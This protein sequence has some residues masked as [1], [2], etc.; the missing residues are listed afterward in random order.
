[1]TTFQLQQGV[2]NFE[3]PLVIPNFLNEIQT[4]NQNII[5][6]A[7]SSQFVYV[8]P[9]VGYLPNQQ[10]PDEA[11]NLM[12]HFMKRGFVLQYDGVA[13]TLTIQWDHPEMSD[14]LMS[15]ISY[16]SPSVLPTLGGW[17]EAGVVYLCETSG[18]DL[19]STSVVTAKRTIQASIEAAALLGLTTTSW[20]FPTVTNSVLQNLY[21][22]VFAQLTAD[23]F[24]YSY[25]AVTGLYAITWGGQI[26]FSFL[27][28]ASAYADLAIDPANNTAQT[29]QVQAGAPLAAWQ[30]VYSSAGL[31][32]PAN[33]SI[34]AEGSQVIGVT[35]Y[36]VT[37]TGNML[38]V[39]F[40][41]LAT[42]TAWN[43]ASGTVYCA[44]DGTLTQS[45]S[46]TGWLLSVGTVVSP[47]SILIDFGAPV[48]R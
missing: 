30:V 18:Q 9:T 8:Y 17:F 41:G 28:G 33:T 23:G 29:I 22:E 32:Y 26:A 21:S 48:F 15:Q 3:L 45:P 34:K 16:A 14:L 47:T 44:P 2:V 5:L 13:A 7:M 6:Q 19:R 20:G 39:Q 36:A 37:T 35:Q 11:Y 1:M 43:W 42:N 27:D 10:I 25:N 24:G 4:I 38:A 31:V 46:S 40:F 12:I